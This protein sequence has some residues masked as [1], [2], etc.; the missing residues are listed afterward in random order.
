VKVATHIH[1]NPSKSANGVAFSSLSQ[2]EHQEGNKYIYALCGAILHPEG[3]VP[4]VTT[5]SKS[6]KINVK[7]SFCSM[8]FVKYIFSFS[9]SDKTKPHVLVH[10][11]WHLKA[12][13]F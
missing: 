8:K 7:F 13:C 1:H 11:S 10:K 5:P 2:K 12:T 9:T 6:T 3:T 4:H